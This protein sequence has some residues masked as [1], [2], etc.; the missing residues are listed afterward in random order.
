MNEG[1]S[2]IPPAIETIIGFATSLSARATALARARWPIPTPLLVARMMVGLV[3]S[4]AYLNLFL[5]MIPIITTAMT[6]PTHCQKE[7]GKGACSG[8]SALLSLTAESILIR[9]T[10]PA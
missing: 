6:I 8:R 1:I 10:T 7:I 2:A 4:L 5:T 3:I 9:E